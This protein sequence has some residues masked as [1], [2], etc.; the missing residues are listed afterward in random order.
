MTD[1]S[2]H[3]IYVFDLD[4]QRFTYINKRVEQLVGR[5]QEYVYAMPGRRRHLRED[6]AGEDPAGRGAEGVE[7]MGKFAN[8]QMSRCADVQM[9]R[10]PFA[11]TLGAFPG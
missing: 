5:D 4:E 1:K 10:C 9:S 3:L 7:L 2:P 8:V 11:R 6:D